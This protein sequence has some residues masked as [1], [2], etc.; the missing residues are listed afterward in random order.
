MVVFFLLMDAGYLVAFTT[1]GGQTIGKM[2]LGLRVVRDG[3]EA[4]PVGTA[5]MRALGAIAST[6]CLG[7]G[8]LPALVHEDRRALHDRLS[9]THVVRFPA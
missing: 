5:L 6:L 3:D 8:L 1:A 7:A 2:A 4:V 9:G